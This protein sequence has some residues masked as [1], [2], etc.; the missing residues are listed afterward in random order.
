[1]TPVPEHAALYQDIGELK[2]LAKVSE[3]A[4]R[5]L[6]GLVREITEKMATKE[7]VQAA[8]SAHGRRISDLE[9]DKRNLKNGVKFAFGAPPLIAAIV[10]VIRFSF[11]HVK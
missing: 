2:A 3:A 9:N 7:D 1:M 6:F 10:E 5:E 11:G 4:Q 8:M